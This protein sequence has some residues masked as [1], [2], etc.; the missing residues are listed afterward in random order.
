M[1]TQANENIFLKFCKN[2]KKSFFQYT[3][4]FIEML[5]FNEKGNIAI[6]TSVAF[7]LFLNIIVVMVFKDIQSII[8]S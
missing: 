2:I 8:I 6:K 1:S 3:E 5:K 4:L 7:L